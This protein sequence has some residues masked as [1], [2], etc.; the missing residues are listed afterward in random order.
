MA[1]Q[2]RSKDLLRKD[3]WLLLQEQQ[4]FLKQ[5]SLKV[6]GNLAKFFA[7]QQNAKC[8]AAFMPLSLEVHID[9]SRW[10][11]KDFVFPRCEGQS[12]SFYR[13]NPDTFEKHAK[14]QVLEP[15]PALAKKV[16]ANE[17]DGFLLPGLAFSTKGQRLGKGKAYYDKYLQNLSQTK[18]GLTFEFLMK[19]EIPQESTDVKM[20]FVITDEQIIEV[21]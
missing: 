9:Y 13:A 19:E 17:I 18:V 12:M 16:N 14:W 3:A 8:W 4:D 21:N 11:D 6:E 15:N 5:K 7:S 20:D 2:K 10:P 1:L